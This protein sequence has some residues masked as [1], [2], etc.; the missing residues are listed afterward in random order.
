MLGIVG[1]GGMLSGAQYP[2]PGMQ[3]GLYGARWHGWGV[4]RSGSYRG[5]D[6]LDSQRGSVCWSVA[7]DCPCCGAELL[8]DGDRWLGD[9][10]WWQ[11]DFHGGLID[12][13]GWQSDC[14]RWLGNR[15]RRQSDCHRWL[16]ESDRR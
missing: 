1:I 2:Y 14:R 8:S 13:D 4:D 10:G 11:S 5:D 12:G 15:G 9:R 16:I 6:G 3:V 7:T